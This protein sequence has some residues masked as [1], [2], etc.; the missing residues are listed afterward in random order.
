M[1]LPHNYQECKDL[2]IGFREPAYHF[3]L[4]LPYANWKDIQR[5][6][7]FCVK[8]GIW[9]NLLEDEPGFHQATLQAGSEQLYTMHYQYSLATMVYWCFHRLF[10]NRQGEGVPSFS[11][12]IQVENGDTLHV[13]IIVGGEGLNKYTAKSWCQPVAASF[14]KGLKHRYLETLGPSYESIEWMAIRIPIEIAINE[15]EKGYHEKHISIMQYKSRAGQMHALRVRPQEFIAN[16][17]LPKNYWP[18]TFVGPS[19]FTPDHD[20]FIER[21]KTFSFTLVGDKILELGIRRQLRDDLQGDFNGQQSEPVFG[22]DP[23]GA[24]PKVKQARWDNVTQAG[25]KMTKREGL[26]L[27][28]MNRALED[29]LLTYEQLVDK[30]P[31]MV[32]MFES[33]PGGSRLIEQT[34]GMV[35]IKLTQKYTAMTYILKR[36]PDGEVCAENKVFRLL[37]L[38]G[39]NPWQVGHWFCTWLDKKAGKQNTVSLFGPASTGK[40]NLAKALV[41]CVKLYGCVNHSNRNFVFND[42]AAKLIVWWEECIMN[43]EWVE[44]AKCCLGGTEFRIDRKHKESQLLPQTP[45]IISTNNDIY[46]VVGG[47]YTTTV[48]KKPLQERVVQINLMKQLSPNFG[49]IPVQDVADWLVDCYNNYDCTLQGFLTKWGLKSVPNDFPG[50]KL[51]ASHSQ[52]WTLHENGLCLHC[53][54]YLPLNEFDADSLELSGESGEFSLL[55]TPVKQGLV[56]FYLTEFHL[57]PLT[58][59]RS[60]RDQVTPEQGERPISKASDG[61]PNPKRRRLDQTRSESDAPGTSTSTVSLVHFS[62]IRKRLNYEQSETEEDKITESDAET[63]DGADP[64]IWGER[65][66]VHSLGP[67]QEPIVLH[68]FE[69]LGDSDTEFGEGGE[70]ERK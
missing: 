46:T 43:Q 6:L 7:Q 62:N 36:Y 1:D 16:Y 47:N 38:Q 39:Y 69:T 41:N 51:C 8:G 44:P 53:G 10:K 19:T 37:N 22:G 13:H 68:C 58:G 34:L 32:V 59:T 4:R 31:E 57:T 21:E 52:D 48:H 60:N 5:E 61:R 12:F 25:G 66:G 45:V 63:E 50:G 29:D 49:E 64:R 24:L 20:Y 65:L 11:S 40:T 26:V 54:G 33:Q 70:Q 67:D 14:F 2:L 3:I 18:N 35:H 30:H 9:R 17:F 28:C 56:D 55:S 42:C 15:C 23:L 27:D